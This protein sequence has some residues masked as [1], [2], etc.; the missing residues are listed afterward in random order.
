MELGELDQKLDIELLAE[1]P[2]QVVARMP[3]AGN[4]Q[5]HG[6]LHGGASLALG[7]FLGSWA[8]SLHAKKHG[9]VAVGV[10]V[11][12]THHRAVRDGYVTGTAVPLHLGSRVTSHQVT[13]RDDAG[14]LVNTVRITNLLI[15][16]K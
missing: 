4:R 15:D 8:A 10:D 5:P 12:A 1:A 6:L 3:V 16:P 13:I 14:H 2:E 11:N 9:K 7:E